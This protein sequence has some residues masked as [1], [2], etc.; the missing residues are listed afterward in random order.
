MN[1]D[2]KRFSPE[3]LKPGAAPP[4]DKAVKYHRQ[5]AI[6]IRYARIIIMCVVCDT[7]PTTH[8]TTDVW[9]S[10]PT[11]NPFGAISRRVENS[12]DLPKIMPKSSDLTTGILEQLRWLGCARTNLRLHLEFETVR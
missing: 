9:F 5:Q 10:Q 3:S 12:S 8:Q 4:D 6:M 1:I 7:E 2:L 11:L